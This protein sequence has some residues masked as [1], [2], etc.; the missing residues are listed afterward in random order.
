MQTYSIKRAV[1]IQ[2]CDTTKLVHN[3]KA[4]ITV[5]YTRFRVKGCM[6]CLCSLVSSDLVNKQEIF[7]STVVHMY[8]QV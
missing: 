5:L 7:L 2:L 1:D 8:L 4:N 6:Q 3:W